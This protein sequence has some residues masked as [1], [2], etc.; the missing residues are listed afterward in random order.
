MAIF[1]IKQLLNFHELLQL[2]SLLLMCF[3]MY[4]GR[5][6]HCRG[7]LGHSVHGHG[8]YRAASYLAVAA[9]H[10]YRCEP[11]PKGGWPLPL[12]FDL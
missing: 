8:G 4:G 9:I 11:R 2:S 7:G 3:V 1:L 6:G 10:M 5:E 12:K